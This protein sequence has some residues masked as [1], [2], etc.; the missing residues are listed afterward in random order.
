MGG[1]INNGFELTDQSVW[2]GD[3][4]FVC[5]DA[6]ERVF[7]GCWSSVPFANSIS[8]EASGVLRWGGCSSAIICI[9]AK[10]SGCSS[11]AT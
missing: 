3:Y 2:V 8:H 9:L 6:R 4:G 7:G 11:L 1:Q 10:G 5:N